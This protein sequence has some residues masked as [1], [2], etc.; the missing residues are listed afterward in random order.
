MSVAFT[1]PWKVGRTLKMGEVVGERGLIMKIGKLK[2]CL[3]N[4]VD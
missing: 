4:R 2:A 1:E 3:K